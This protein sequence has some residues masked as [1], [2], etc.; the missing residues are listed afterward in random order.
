MLRLLWI[1]VSRVQVPLA[2]PQ[3]RVDTLYAGRAELASQYEL[4][5]AGADWIA[6]LKARFGLK[7]LGE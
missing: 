6:E 7:L 4:P 3:S 2:T 5:P 1:W